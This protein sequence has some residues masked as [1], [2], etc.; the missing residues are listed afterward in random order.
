M[1]YRL[2]WRSGADSVETDVVATR[3]GVLVCR[4]DLDLARTTD[5][6]GRPDLADRRRWL[7]ADGTDTYGWFVGDLDLAEVRTLRAR[8]RWPEL[9]PRSARYD[10]QVGVLTLEELLDLR[11]QESAR[12]GR[13]L[14]VHVEVKEPALFEEHGLAV[15]EPLLDQLRHH[16]LTTAL[17]PVSVMSFDAN[18]LKR[19][20]QQLDVELLRLVDSDQPVRRG[21]LARVA[22]YASGVGLHKA[23]LRRGKDRHPAKVAD[24]VQSAG[25]DLHVWTLRS[26]NR[27]LPRH[28]RLPGD[29]GTHGLAHREVRRLVDLG[30]DGL[31]TDFPEVAVGVLRERAAHRV[32]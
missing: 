30:V 9:R 18:V 13:P 7:H 31:I 6:A 8:E 4:H 27:Y 14:G 11:E 12:A 28:L 1:A 21:S 24:A 3:D 26:E 15:H 19:L 17:A 16:G 5:V 2:A 20:R 32:A 25:L 29:A 23:H 22:S 10:G